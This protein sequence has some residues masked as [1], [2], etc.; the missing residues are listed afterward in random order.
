MKFVGYFDEKDL[1]NGKDKKA[2]EKAQNETGL[3]YTETKITKRNGKT[4][5][6]CPKVKNRK[7]FQKT[8]DKPFRI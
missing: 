4:S 3:K 8:V 2:V 7:K 5:F 1:Q 6:S